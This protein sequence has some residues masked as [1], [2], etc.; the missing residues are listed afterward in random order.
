M[1][2]TRRDGHPNLSRLPLDAANEVAITRTSGFP[3]IPCWNERCGRMHE[4]ARMYSLCS[5]CGVFE[6]GARPCKL[7][8][9]VS[10]PGTQFCDNR[11]RGC[12]GTASDFGPE[13]TENATP[14]SPAFFLGQQVAASVRADKK[15]KADQLEAWRTGRDAQGGHAGRGGGTPAGGA[16]SRRVA[17]GST[18][19]EPDGPPAWA[20]R[21][22]GKGGGQEGA[23]R[24]V[25]TLMN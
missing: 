10:R 15:D 24:P 23:R 13:L 4:P 12:L 8:K 20:S 19:Y 22:G 25:P 18:E 5:W 2:D 6:S 9:I 17:W 11:G 21:S 3:P 7:C 16:A 14:G 1:T